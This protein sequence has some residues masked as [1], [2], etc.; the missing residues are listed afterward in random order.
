MLTIQYCIM[1][2][3]FY[4]NYF[5]RN[6][7]QTIEYNFM[8]CLYKYPYGEVIKIVKSTE[9][10]NLFLEVFTKS[11]YPILIGVYYQKQ[12]IIFS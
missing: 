11:N 2:P 8:M 6:I 12:T 3:L 4:Y 5:I 10:F 7:Q 9:D 1:H